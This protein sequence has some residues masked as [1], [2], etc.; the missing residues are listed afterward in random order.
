[1]NTPNPST[2]LE[3]GRLLASGSPPQCGLLVTVL[4]A[5]EGLPRTPTRT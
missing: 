5:Q 1:M 3:G 4:E 2:F